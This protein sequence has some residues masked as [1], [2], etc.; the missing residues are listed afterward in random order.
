VIREW[1][2]REQRWLVETAARFTPEPIDAPRWFYTLTA[3]RLLLLLLAIAI[4]PNPF[5][6]LAV[7]LASFLLPPIV[8]DLIWQRR[9]RM[10]RDQ[11]PAAVSALANC[12][13]AGLSLPQAL[14][15]LAENTA[16]PIR[17]EFRIITNGY[18]LGLDLQSILLDAKRR[19]SLQEFNLVVS[20]LL[21][22]REMGGD[23]ATT[24]TR[25]A[26]S[27]EKLKQMMGVIRA[28]TSEGRTNIKVLIAAPIFMLLMMATVDSEG[29]ALLF[30]TLEGIAVLTAAVLLAGAGVFWASRIVGQEV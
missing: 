28:E 3:L 1:A 21:V 9:R 14:G 6:A 13:R 25:I 12:V 27:L 22:N 17:N 29:V 2:S 23:V 11:L 19:L 7:W 5:L 15:R 26:V 10:I 24:L 20:A 16:M 4:I 18:A 30:H 8:V